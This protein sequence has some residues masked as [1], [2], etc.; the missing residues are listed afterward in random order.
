[1]ASCGKGSN[2]SYHTK[3]QEQHLLLPHGYPKLGMYTCGTS[4]T[5]F[6]SPPLRSSKWRRTSGM[7][8]DPWVVTVFILISLSFS[9]SLPISSPTRPPPSLNFYVSTSHL[10]SNE[11]HILSLFCDS[12]ILSYYLF[13]H[14]VSFAL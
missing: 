8:V 7:P 6:G 1:M 4:R 13:Q 9:L 14:M 5:I 3:L 10:V 11:I 2:C 12:V